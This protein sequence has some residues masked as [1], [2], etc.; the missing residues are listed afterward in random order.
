MSD[1][2]DIVTRNCPPP[3]LLRDCATYKSHRI[4]FEIE[5]GP[6]SSADGNLVKNV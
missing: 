4:E 5:P 2:V 3:T 1:I 6:P